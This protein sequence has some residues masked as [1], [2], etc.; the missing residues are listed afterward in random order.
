MNYVPPRW[1]GRGK[2]ADDSVGG[3]K[4]S[5]LRT[6]SKRT[7]ASREEGSKGMVEDEVGFLVG[8]LGGNSLTNEEKQKKIAQMFFF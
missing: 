1:G 3:K 5:C 8:R 4:N 7:W 2:L 6:Q